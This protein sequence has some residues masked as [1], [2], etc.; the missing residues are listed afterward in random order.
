MK[1]I[2][3]IMLIDLQNSNLTEF[4]DNLPNNLIYLNLSNY[5]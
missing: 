3:L 1:T 2:L 4:L 5:N